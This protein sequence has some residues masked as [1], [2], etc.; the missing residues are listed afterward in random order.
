MN[1]HRSILDM[2]GNLIGSGISSICNLQIFGRGQV[3]IGESDKRIVIFV[4]NAANTAKCS[5]CV[6]AAKLRDN[7]QTGQRSYVFKFCH[8][9]I[10]SNATNGRTGNISIRSFDCQAAKANISCINRNVCSKLAASILCRRAAIAV[11]RCPS[12]GKRGRNIRRQRHGDADRAACCSGIGRS[13]ISEVNRAARRRCGSAA[14]Y[15]GNNLVSKLG[16]FCARRHRQRVDCI[17][18]HDTNIAA[19]IAF[20]KALNQDLLNRRQVSVYIQVAVGGC[21]SKRLNRYDFFFC[22]KTERSE[23]NLRCVNHH[24]VDLHLVIRRSCGCH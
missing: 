24:V 6:T 19:D 4:L 21:C 3:D 15:K 16:C 5:F 18:L 10:T 14:E 20:I 13:V 1:S 12:S 22:R 9:N 8:A 7:F 2:C 11:Q 23:I 17:S